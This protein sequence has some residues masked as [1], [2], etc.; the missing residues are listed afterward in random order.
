[1]CRPKQDNQNLRI[2]PDLVQIDHVLSQNIQLQNQVN[3]LQAAL[4]Q[5]QAATIAAYLIGA[6]ERVD[7]KREIK[8]IKEE[9]TYMKMTNNILLISLSLV[10]AMNL[11]AFFCSC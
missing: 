9:L 7:L 10:I 11:K 4:R 6:S 2:L 1:M 5:Q 8:K 3:Q